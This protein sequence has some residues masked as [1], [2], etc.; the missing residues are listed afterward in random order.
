[1]REEDTAINE[2]VVG[3]ERLREC[4]KRK[5]KEKKGVCESRRS[6]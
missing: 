5:G 3:H 2:P 6:K 4:E 1:M